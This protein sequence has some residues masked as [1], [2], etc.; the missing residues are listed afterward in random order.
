MP[1]NVTEE[2]RSGFIRQEGLLEWRFVPLLTGP[3]PAWF[4]VYVQVN[5]EKE[6]AYRLQM[7]TLEAFVPLQEC[8]SKRRDRR[9]RLYLPLFPGYVFIRTVLDNSVHAEVVK[10]PGAVWI[11]RNSAGPLPIPDHQ[12]ESLQRLLAHPQVLVTGP[13]IHEGDLVRVCNGPLTGCIGVLVR[14]KRAKGRL[15]V[16]LDIIQQSVG[17]ELD[18]E[19]VEAVKPDELADVE[20]RK[21]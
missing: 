17:V 13:L 16:N 1:T 10:T 21:K 4:A 2:S 9:K 18:V 7:K 19:D 12:M 11:I 3:D 15:V 20:R 6:V 8:W 14:S 5:H